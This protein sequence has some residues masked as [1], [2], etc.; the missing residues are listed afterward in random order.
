MKKEKIRRINFVVNGVKY[1]CKV[2]KIEPQTS[3]THNTSYHVF[4]V[5]EKTPIF[6]SIVNDETT[7]DNI[8]HLCVYGV[9]HG[10]NNDLLNAFM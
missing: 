2:F 8:K 7:M 5:G 1:L 4:K 10:G 3:L 6:G 9:L